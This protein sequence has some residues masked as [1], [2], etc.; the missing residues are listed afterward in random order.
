M[1]QKP[2]PVLHMLLWGF[3][4]GTVLALLYIV[5]CLSL[6]TTSFM[7]TLLM[8]VQP[9]A[10]LIALQYG[11][12]TGTG[13]GLVT[14]VVLWSLSRSFQLPFSRAE[15]Q[16]QRY[17]VYAIISTQTIISGFVIIT[18]FFWPTLFTYGWGIPIGGTAPFPLAFFFPPF[19]AGVA[20]AYA[21]H[22]YMFRLWLWSEK[23]Y[24]LEKEKVKNIER[25]IDHLHD[26]AKNEELA[27][28]DEAEGQFNHNQK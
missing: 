26:K 13:L 4:S 2:N 7:D 16:A 19:I 23:Q 9:F 17:K 14:G 1:Q 3:G 15:M 12:I 20:A 18:L 11:G 8:F 25:M 5:F 6:G 27:V 10:W 22:R 21:A 28:E 24:K